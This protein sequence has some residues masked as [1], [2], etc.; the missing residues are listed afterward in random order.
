MNKENIQFTQLRRQGIRY[1]EKMIGNEWSDY[2]AHDPGITILEQVCY[3]L[4][5]LGYRISYDF[6]DLLAEGGENWAD[7]FYRASE[8]LTTHPVTVS[9]L[10]KLAMDVEGVKNAWVELIEEPEVPL[11]YHP[12][13]KEISTEEEP[14]ASQALQLKGLYRVSIEL[15]GA[16]DIYVEKVT[17]DVTRQ[18]HSHRGLC[19]DFESVQILKSSPI[20]IRSHIEIDP[21]EDAEA[22]LVEIYQQLADYMSPR[23]PFYSLEQ[24]LAKGLRLDEIFDGPM[25]EHGFIETTK[26]EAQQRRQALHS[27]DMIQVIMSVK[28]VR[29][30]QQL[31]IEGNG[32]KDSWV[33][34]LPDRDAAPILDV[35]GSEITLMRE[36]IE[37]GL[38]QKS[39]K[40]AYDARQRNSVLFRKLDASERDILPPAGR[41]R[42][43]ADYYSI[44]HQFPQVYGIGSAGL[45]PSAS[46]LRQA[47]ARQLKGYLM[48]YDQLLSTLFTQLSHA[49]D[50]FSF[51]GSGCRSYF[52]DMVDDPELNLAPIRRNGDEE[53]QTKLQQMIDQSPY[54]CKA[55]D[56]RNRFLNH[57]LARFSEQFTD[58]S[59]LLHGASPV[60]ETESDELRVSEKL[61]KDKQAFLQHYPSISAARGGAF[62]YLEPPGVDN[63]SGL[64]ERIRL[65][66]GLSGEGEEAF[67]IVEHILLRA[68]K[69]D[70]QQNLPFLEAAYSKDPFSL[71]LSFVFADWP[72]Q[73]TASF[74]HL[75]EQTVRDET[76]A[77]LT[78]YIH[79]FDKN[80]MAD[81]EAAYEDWLTALQHNWAA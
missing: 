69:A 52:A 49:T 16:S 71:Q 65:K 7:E 59:L 73:F 67:Y 22:L 17:R 46:Q 77:H 50:L 11:F 43:V 24:M 19:E 45:S 35:S 5:D 79:W 3:A 51:K 53:H 47:Q 37:V 38:N 13:K 1:L 39:V 41:K 30:V 12:G 56:R 48:F 31:E 44:Q 75:V 27:S 15:S 6:P 80:V 32:R 66:L 4:T 81:F 33:L 34:E 23:I 18:L 42:N 60:T 70:Q 58:Y 62:N 10:R 54:Q 63:V 28:G 76:P 57:M 14:P 25:L 55:G 8:I 26:L 29:A 72:G 20:R 9:D 36:Q 40:A 68:M 21:V 2:N 61:I 78:V 64:Q 74:R